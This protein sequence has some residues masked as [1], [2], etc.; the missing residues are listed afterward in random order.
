[1]RRPSI[2]YRRYRPP[3][4]IPTI[5]MSLAGKMEGP[6]KPRP[7][8]PLQNML[9]VSRIQGGCTLHRTAMYL[10]RKAI[11]IIRSGKKSGHGSSGHQS[12]KALRTVRT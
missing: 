6:P 7:V 10:W 5:A 4:P 2:R 1:M 3:N 8:L 11:R 12:R 9:T